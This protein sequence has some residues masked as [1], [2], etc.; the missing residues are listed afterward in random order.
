MWDPKGGVQYLW[1]PEG[2]VW[3]VEADSEEKWLLTAGS[4]LQEPRG[5]IR[6]LD[7][8]QS[9]HGLLRHVYST[10]QVLMEPPVLAAAHL[11]TTETSFYF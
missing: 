6:A 9:L 4:G 10:E 1:D 2:D 5:L 8:R 11:R 3:F 7:V